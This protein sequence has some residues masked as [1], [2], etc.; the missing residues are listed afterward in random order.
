MAN[1]VPARRV[2]TDPKM[3]P[4]RRPLKP[5]TSGISRQRNRQR[6]VDHGIHGVHGQE[7]AETVVNGVTERQQPGLAEQHV[8]G[9][10]EHDHDAHQAEHRQRRPGS[11]NRRQDRKRDGEREPRPD[12]TRHRR[13][14]RLRQGPARRDVCYAARNIT[15]CSR[16]PMRPVGRKI[17]ISTSSK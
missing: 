2:E 4:K 15:Q 3:M 16:V 12:K 8:I 13:G 14:A 1:A 5:P 6:I 17:K 11:D 7:S 9:Q 10:R